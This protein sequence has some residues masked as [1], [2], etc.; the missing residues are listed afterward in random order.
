MTWPARS[1]SSSIGTQ[2]VAASAI[3]AR[4]SGSMVVPPRRVAGPTAFTIGRTPSR[5]YTA[6]WVCSV[7]YTIRGSKG[8]A[9]V[10]ARG[11]LAIAC[12]Q[13]LHELAVVRHLVRVKDVLGQLELLVALAGFE[14]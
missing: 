13:K 12:A 3:A 7:L 10:R 5:S 11:M 1:C 4:T 8:A 9:H 2:A 14:Q 6:I